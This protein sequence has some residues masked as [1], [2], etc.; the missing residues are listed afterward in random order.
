MYVT[1]TYLYSIV[2]FLL[3][4]KKNRFKTKRFDLT[5][6]VAPPSKPV[7]SGWTKDWGACLVS[8][9]PPDFPEPGSAR[10]VGG[11]SLNFELLRLD[12]ASILYFLCLL[13]MIKLQTKWNEKCNMYQQKCIH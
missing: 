8:P 10:H 13:F 5:F 4:S 1:F 3:H 9:E 11:L 2:I 12:D 6:H 7:F